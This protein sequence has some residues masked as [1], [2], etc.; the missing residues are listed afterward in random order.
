MSSIVGSAQSPEPLVSYS[1]IKEIDHLVLPLKVVQIRQLFN[2]CEVN[3]G[4]VVQKLADYLEVCTC[5]NI[6]CFL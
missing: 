2:K 5:Y 1:V 3:D 4:S 6:M